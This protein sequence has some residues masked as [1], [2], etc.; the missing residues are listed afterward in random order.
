VS[1]D[2]RE[3]PSS[4]GAPASTPEDLGT[5]VRPAARRSTAI[6]STPTVLLVASLRWPIAARLAIAF[7]ELGCRVEVLCPPGHPAEQTRCVARIRRHS[8]LAP[9]YAIRAAIASCEPDL[10]LPCDDDAALQLC[11]LYAKTDPAQRSEELIRDR[12]GRSLGVPDG[13][14]RMA[15][16]GQLAVLAAELGVRTPATA[17]IATRG[18]L[19]CWLEQY[20]FPAVLKLDATWGGL[21]VAVV[22]SLSAAQRVFDLMK[23][24]PPLAKSVMRTLLDRDP[25]YTLRALSPRRPSITVQKFIHGTPANRAVACWN[26]SVLAGT[27]VDAL[28]TQHATGPATV[29][30]VVDNPEMTASAAQLVRRLGVSGL[31]GFDFVKETTTGAAYLIEVNP[32]ATP[33]CHLSIG[34]DRSLPLALFSQITARPPR[35][36]PTAIHQS[37]IAMFPGEWQRDPFSTYLVSAYHDVPWH[38]SKLVRDG[39]DRPW[40]E[41]GM[42]ARLWAR[43]RPQVPVARGA[44]PAGAPATLLVAESTAIEPP[45]NGADKSHSQIGRSVAD[46]ST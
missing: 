4:L 35:A 24:R 11:A 28:R 8:V 25:R 36:L 16:R 15:L 20:G 14:S 46:R 19:R 27:S 23:S 3:K 38:E 31:W 30:R 5:A 42:L 29:V 17:E 39:T 33:T 7:A 21:G 34:A 6:P 37:I 22:D 44:L 10:I 26:G 2:L 43:H 13:Y 12:I 18:D 45:S 41:R 9:L 40:A 32:R 1:G